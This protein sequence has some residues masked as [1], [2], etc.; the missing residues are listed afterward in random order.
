MKRYTVSINDVDI[1]PAAKSETGFTKMDIRFLI[2]DKTVD[3][4]K[5]SFFGLFSLRDMQRTRSITIKI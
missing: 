1:T 4:K 5:L 2:T 3:S